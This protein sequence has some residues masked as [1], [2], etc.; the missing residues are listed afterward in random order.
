[1]HCHRKVITILLSLF[2]VFLFAACRPPVAEEPAPAAEADTLVIYS[3]RS[4][5]LVGPLIEQY[6][7]QSNIAVEVRYGGS[8]E[9]AATILEEGNNSP[10]DV[11][12]AQDAGALGALTA[13]GR[14]SPLPEEILNKVGAHFRGQNNDWVGASGR[15]RVVV[16]NTDT[17]G[18]VDL[19]ADIWGFTAPEWQGKVGWAPTNASFQAFVTALRLIEGEDSARNWLQAMLENQVQSYSN[20][21]S[22]VEAVGRGEITAGFVNHYY[23]FQF[24]AEQGDNFP[25]RNFYLPAAD[26]G[27]MI[28]VAGAGV[29]DSSDA[30]AAALDFVRFLLSAQA[31]QYFADETAEYPL[32]DGIE[33]NPALKPLT[34]IAVP[35][36][37]LGDLADLQGTL[38]L[39]QQVGALD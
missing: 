33:I 21:T 6:Q 9:M 22:I 29:L 17:L 28:N 37:D 8:A 35:A 13:A 12:F 20:N 14:L 25:A 16:Y 3:G 26:A 23:L 31:Q 2:V 38:E 39:L 27:A 10:A 19:P 24:L 36:L 15:A 32:I 1:M 30:P 4:E 34:D 11:F 18:E 7:E 5:N